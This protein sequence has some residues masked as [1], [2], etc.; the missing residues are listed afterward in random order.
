MADTDTD[1]VNKK[2]VDKRNTKALSKYAKAYT[3]SKVVSK[4]YIDDADDKILLDAKA[5]ADQKV[6]VGNI[7]RVMKS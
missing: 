1:L 5:Y 4:K 2:Y 6:G 3:N 7:D